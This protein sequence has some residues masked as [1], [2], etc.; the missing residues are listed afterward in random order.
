MIKIKL[1]LLNFLIILF[2]FLFAIPL[3]NAFA[4]SQKITI[5]F[6]MAQPLT[7]LEATVD[8]GYFKMVE[9]A[10]KGKYLLEVKYF[11]VGSLFGGAGV[12]EGVAKGVVDAGASILS[13][14][15]GRFPVMLTLSQPGI[16]PLVSAQAGSRSV[17]EFY[18]KFRPKEFDDVKILYLYSVPPAWIHSKTPINKLEEIRNLDIR[19]TGA[20]SKGLKALGANPTAAPQDEVYILAQ[21]GIIKASIAPLEVLKVWKQAE[22]FTYS[23]FVPFA[24][25]EQWFIAMNWEMWNRL[26]KDLQ[27]AFDDVAERAVK[28][29]GQIWQ[30][31]ETTVMNWAHKLGHKFIYLSN[32]EMGRWQKLLEP[33]RSAYVTEL[34]SKGFPGE[35]IVDEASKIA[36]ESNTLFK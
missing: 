9:E 5:R 13:Y 17:W 25:H 6:H 27:Q 14:T 35:L 33:I 10:T 32:E 30:S 24:Y 29:A 20:S 36:Q 3:F 4:E 21:K 34:K 16:C 19:A 7:G 18:K 31:H 15:P 22:I 26:P 1:L 8:T 28:Q 23:T 2:I 11:P 12:Y